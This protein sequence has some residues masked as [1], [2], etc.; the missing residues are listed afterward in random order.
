MT[1][2]LVTGASG[3]I[4]KHIVLQ[5]LQAGYEVCGSVRSL[6]RGAE[7]TDAVKPHLDPTLDLDSL[8]TFVELDLTADD[9][10]AA[11]MDGIDVLMHTASPF[12]M[13]APKHEDDLIRPAV[14]G[15]LRALRAASEAGI[16]RVVLTSSTASV[17]YRSPPESGIFDESHWTDVNHPTCAPYAKSKTLAER[18]AWDFIETEAPD[19]QMTTINPGFVIGAPLDGNYGTSMKSILRLLSGK[20]PALPRIGFTSVDVGDVAAAHVGAIDNLDTH[21]LRILVVE[22]FMWF[23]DIAHAIANAYPDRR[24]V[25]RLAPNWLIRLLALFDKQL[26][27]IAPMLDQKFDI[28]NDRARELLAINFKDTRESAAESARYLIDNKLV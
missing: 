15:T 8:L 21:G 1:K 2:V 13:E 17:L 22:R 5:L 9:G 24:I 20:D 28:S 10:W 25:T 6:S 18:T 16:K 19:I 26:G 11:A 3:Y 23:A 12:P 4:A 7:I 14:D 27:S